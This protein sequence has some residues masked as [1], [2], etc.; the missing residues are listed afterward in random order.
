MVVLTDRIDSLQKL[1]NIPHLD[2]P[3]RISSDQEITSFYFDTPHIFDPALMCLEVNA[4]L[5]DSM[6][7]DLDFP[8][9]GYI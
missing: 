8:F 4:M 6:V 2:G 1:Q 3:C 9:F 7:P 5:V